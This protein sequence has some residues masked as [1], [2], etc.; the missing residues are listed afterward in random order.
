L[1]A[2]DGFAAEGPAADVCAL[3]LGFRVSKLIAFAVA[4]ALCLALPA[5]ARDLP[6]RPDLR[7]TPGAVLTTDAATICQP[8]YAKSVRHTSGKL[9][10]EIYRAYGIDRNSGHFEI[11]NLVSL[12]LGGADVA[13]NLWPESYDTTPWN[14]RLKD[15]LENRLHALVCAGPLKLEQAQRE[16]AADWIAAYEKYVARL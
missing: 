16:I 7:L 1:D 12:G 15:R 8:G 2:D 3:H 4:V 9:K 14:A 11:D 5:A 6:I 13:A 10:A